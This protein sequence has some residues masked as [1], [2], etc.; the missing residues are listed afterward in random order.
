M[1][2]IFG[3]GTTA[4]PVNWRPDASTRGTT[5]IL[6]TCLITLGLCL[7]SALHLNIP[8]HGKSS[9]QKCYKC[10]WLLVGLFAPEIVAFT[11]WAQLRA[12]RR[13][14]NEMKQLLGEP[15]SLSLRDKFWRLLRVGRNGQ[16]RST[17]GRDS[18]EGNYTEQHNESQTDEEDMGSRQFNVAEETSL[19]E[20]RVIRH[21]HE[22]KMVQKRAM[23]P[24]LWIL[25]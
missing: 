9:Q 23:V 3:N 10:G 17:S 18:E 4:P 1:F 20:L 14:D 8:Q 24:C 15:P 11:A 13:L 7:W 22:P 12:A 16:C 25:S 2:D 5:E 6:S 19:Q 21:G